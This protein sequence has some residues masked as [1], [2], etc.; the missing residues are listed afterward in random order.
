MNNFKSILKK[1]KTSLIV[2]FIIWFAAEIFL[3][4]AIAYTDFKSTVNGVLDWTLFL[5]GIIP[6]ISSFTS[7]L[8]SLVLE[9]L[10]HC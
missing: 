10:A 3:I 6:N 2:S 7:F 8:Q 4:S 5:E 1:N 9:L